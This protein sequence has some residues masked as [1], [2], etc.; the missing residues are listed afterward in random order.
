MGSLADSMERAWGQSL[1][2][3]MAKWTP[4]VDIK[5]T[6]KEFLISAAVPGVDKADLHVD[7]EQD[8]ITLRGERKLDKE[9]EGKDGVHRMEQIYGSFTRSFTLP[10][11]VDA[12]QVK[13][14]YKDG[15]LKLRLP[16]TE[17]SRGKSIEIE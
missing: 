4:E 7:V 2:G 5:E 12:G 6:E 14:S 3:G 15:V 1:A 11:P 16:K 13:A 17:R 9:Y 10:H 8:N